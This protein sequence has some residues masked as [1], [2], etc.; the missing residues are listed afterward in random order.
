MEDKYR[1]SLLPNGPT[2]RCVCSDLEAPTDPD[3]SPPRAVTCSLALGPLFLT[4]TPNRSHC[5]LRWP[6]RL[7]T[8]TQ[9]FVSRLPSTVWKS[10]YPKSAFHK[11]PACQAGDLPRDAGLIP[12][13][14]RSAGE[15]NGYSLQYSCLENPMGRGAWWATIHWVTK[16]WTQLSMHTYTH[17]SRS[18]PL[19]GWFS[20]QGHLAKSG[21]I[22]GC[23]T[24]RE[25]SY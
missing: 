7:T 18:T 4:D 1:A 17:I 16:R 20:P 3:P 25:G 8:C 19:G 22:S 6:P 23:H 9:F 2:C 11:E 10:T 12:G 5:F 14:G 15:R 21:H 13:W 24:W